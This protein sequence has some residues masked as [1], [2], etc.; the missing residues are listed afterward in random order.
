MQTL[1][2]SFRR[3]MPRAQAIDY[4]KIDNPDSK[5]ASHLT[6]CISAKEPGKATMYFLGIDVGTGGT[7]ALVHR[8]A[9]T[10]NCLCYGRASSLYI[11]AN[12]LGGA[13]SSRLVARVRRGSAQGAGARPPARRSDFVR[14]FVW[15]NAW[16]RPAGRASARRTACADLVRRHDRA[17]KPGPDLPTPC[18]T[19]HSTHLQSRTHQFH[20][21]QMPVGPGERTRELEQGSLPHAAQR[22]RAISVDGR[23]RNRRRSRLG[24]SV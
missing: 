8:R 2:N 5:H 6:D 17:T 13:G 24:D 23:T 10:C 4:L 20:T 11:T 16:G 19:P 14:W 12:R 1:Q 15:T 7:R 9:R 3:V 21:D 18:R 22:L